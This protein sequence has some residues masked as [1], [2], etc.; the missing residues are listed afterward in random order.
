M[1]T[2][3]PQPIALTIDTSDDNATAAGGPVPRGARGCGPVPDG[4]HLGQV[5]WFNADKNYGFIRPLDGG[6]DVFVHVADIQPKH[7]VN[8]HRDPA[9]RTN[10]AKL[11]S[12]EYVVYERRPPDAPGGRA[13]AARVSGLYDADGAP[14]SLVCD[15]GTVRFNSYSR[16]Q[17][18]ADDDEAPVRVVRVGPG[19]GGAASDASFRTPEPPPI[20]TEPIFE[21][22]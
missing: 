22:P 16:R 5:K 20:F 13:K 14:G 9:L 8:T 15:H 4:F 17:F 7:V 3:R 18:G 1:S 21:T 12:G 6:P 10:N 11:I 2:T 19:S